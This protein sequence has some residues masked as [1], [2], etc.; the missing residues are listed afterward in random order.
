[1]S[2]LAVSDINNRPVIIQV[3]ASDDK[4][5]CICDKVSLHIDNTSGCL[6]IPPIAIRNFLYSNRL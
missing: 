3:L 4:V 5:L 1:M 2:V 6:V